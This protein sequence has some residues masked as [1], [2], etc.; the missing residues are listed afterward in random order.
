MKTSDF[1]VNFTAWLDGQLEPKKIAA[2]EQELRARGFDPAA[3]RA[4]A[5]QTSTL[6]RKHSVPPEMGNADFFQHQLMRRIQQM[7]A[8]PKVARSSWWTFPRLAWAGAF[9]LL[10]AAVLFKTSIPVGEPPM[11][12][13][14]FATIIDAR[15]YEPTISVDTVYDPRSNVTVLWIDGLDYMSGDI[16]AQ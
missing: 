2:F 8:V 1:E 14:Y 13:D 6:L 16:V 9:C 10:V 15:T 7:E 5:D 11:R 4:T 12:S 3:E